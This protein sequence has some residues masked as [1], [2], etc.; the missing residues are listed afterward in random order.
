MQ[1]SLPSPTS[2]A[3]WASFVLAGLGLW[4]VLHY[5]LLLALLTGLTVNQLIEALA[6]RCPQRW[7]THA[8]L[9]A[10]IVLGVLVIAI[11]TPV[12]IAFVGWAARLATEWPDFAGYLQALL[13]RARAQVPASLQQ[14]LPDDA[15]QVQAAWIA[16]LHSH[17]QD[18][19]VV[20]R[21]AV[22]AIVHALVGMV[23]GALV[24]FEAAR[25]GSATRPF[26][27]ALTERV[28]RFANAFTQIVFAQFRISLLN[29][30]LTAIFLW[31]VMPMLGHDLPWVKSLIV[32]TFVAGLLP[33]IGNLISNVAIVVVALSV[34]WS[35]AMAALVF[36]VLIHKL[37]YFLNARIV[38]HRIHATAWEILIA[39]VVL[40]AIYGLAGVVAAPVFYA[41]LKSELMQAR[42]V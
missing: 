1:S 29:T 40:E 24:A 5:H 2:T 10:V 41:W 42:M 15:H 16:W 25:P 36:L 33:V 38:G 26:A 13:D 39:M 4:F 37:E 8:R 18:I 21:T 19:Q 7:S 6:R 11:L 22:A 12:V 20:G 27:Q 3:R 17:L 34:S 28:D 35:A 32:L 31:L 30:A 23:L 9:V 14:Y